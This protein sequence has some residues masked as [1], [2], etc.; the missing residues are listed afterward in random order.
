M[1]R[2]W[3]IDSLQKLE[4]STSELAK[5]VKVSRGHIAHIIGGTRTP[6]VPLA[7]KIAKVLKVEWTLFFNEKCVK[8]QQNKITA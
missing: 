5:K 6:S 8:K 2:Q 1:K 4:I 3:M 7:K